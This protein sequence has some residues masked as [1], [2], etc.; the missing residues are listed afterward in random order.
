MKAQH[1]NVFTMKTYWTQLI[2]KN[3][4]TMYMLQFKT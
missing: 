4:K 3:Q 2:K 1:Y